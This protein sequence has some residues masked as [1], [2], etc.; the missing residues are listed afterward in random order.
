MLRK[1][2]DQYE[3]LQKIFLL[4]A[5][6]EGQTALHIAAMNG[7]QNM[8]RTLYSAR[9]NPSVVDSEGKI[10][11]MFCILRKNPFLCC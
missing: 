10:R 7:D 9:A 6:A 1:Y 3:I 4:N 2:N 11:A 5:Q 8:I